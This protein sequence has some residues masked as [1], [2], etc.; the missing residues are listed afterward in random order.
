MNNKIIIYTPF[1]VGRFNTILHEKEINGK[2]FSLTEDWIISR[3]NFWKDN[4]LRS[5]QN[6]DFSDFL[7]YL[8]C[9][10]STRDFCNDIFNDSIKKDNRINLCFPYDDDYLT[11]INILNNTYN[12][13]ILTRLDSDDMYSQ[14]ALRL[15]WECSNSGY[16]WMNF[17]YGYGRDIK[18]NKFYIYDAKE[19]GPFF[20]WS[21]TKIDEIDAGDH[22]K[23]CNFGPRRLPDG[24]FL[25][26]ITSLNTSTYYQSKYFIKE[27]TDINEINTIKTRFGI[28][29]L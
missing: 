19:S 2:H 3:Y 23:V 14:D 4:T 17:R 21:T 16:T 26:N 20:A 1:N 22:S 24:N 27:I 5:L 8:Q 13:K 25:V 15:I 11:E 28:G 18:Q 10:P 9:D 7:L 12:K 29:D 6:Q